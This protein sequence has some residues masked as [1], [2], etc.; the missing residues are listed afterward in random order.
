MLLT[1]NRGVIDKSGKDDVGSAFLFK[2]VIL[3]GISETTL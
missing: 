3:K 1:A 2:E